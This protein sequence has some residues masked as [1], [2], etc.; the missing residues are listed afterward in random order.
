MS[1]SR[2]IAPLWIGITLAL[3]ADSLL[4]Q[5]A[6]IAYGPMITAD[7][8]RK[9]AAAAVAEGK[10]NGWTIAVAVVDTGGHLVHFERIDGTQVGSV[11]VAQEKARSSNNFKRPT[12]AFE[13]GLAGGR[14]AILGLSG[15][16]PLEG[17]LPIVVDNRIIGAIGVS[18]ASS[19]QDGMA[20]KAGVDALGK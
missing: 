14:Q 16:V 4:A 19:Q 20:A 15:A 12:K 7:Q 5:G 10:K 18:G 11:V 8:A 9:A 1:T 6:P 17:G 2:K 3:A 13:D